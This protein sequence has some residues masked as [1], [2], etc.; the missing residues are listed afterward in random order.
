[1]KLSYR[2]DPGQLL[3]NNAGFDRTRSAER[4]RRFLLDALA[5][6]Y[7]SAELDV[8]WEAGPALG[9]SVTGVDDPAR[10]RRIRME[11]EEI[12]KAVRDCSP[13]PAR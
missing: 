1:M 9:A 11:L 2:F 13:W 10:T 8:S 6:R 7:P 12:A 4:Y 5:E 3:R